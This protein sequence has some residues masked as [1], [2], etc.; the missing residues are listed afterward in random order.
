[1]RLHRRI[2]PLLAAA[3]CFGCGTDSDTVFLPLSVEF[4][5]SS[6]EAPEGSE[7]A[8]IIVRL[9]APTELSVSVDY[10]VRDVTA[11]GHDA[12]NT[13]DYSLAASG[14]LVFEP[15]STTA[16]LELRHLDDDLAEIDEQLRIELT[17]PEGA[18]LGKLDHHTHTISDDDRELL[19]D[20]QADFGATGD[21][22]TDDT[23]ALQ[24]AIDRAGLSSAAVLLLPPG[25]YQVTSLELP[26][27]LSL[28]GYGA[29]LRQ[30]PRQ[31]EN[32]KLLRLTHAG[33]DDSA[34]TLVQ[35]L[36]FDGN[37]DAQGEFT[38]WQY[39]ESDLFSLSANPARSGR[40]QLVAEDLSFE[41]TGGNGLLLG[42]NTKSS[43]CQ[44]VG[45]EVFTDLLK[46]SGGYS[47]L[48][49]REIVAAGSV[50]TTSIAITGQ[51]QGYDASHT[52]DVTL[53]DIALENGD[54]EIDVR[55]GSSVNARGITVNE[56]PF[57]LRAVRSSVRISDSSLVMGPPL[58]RFNRI[59]APYD[60][61]FENSE[62]TLHETIERTVSEPESDRTL[63]LVGV[64]WDD[65]D[66]AFEEG[67]QDVLVERLGRQTLRFDDCNFRVGS[68]VE[69][70]DTSY[71]AGSVAETAD[72]ADE[73]ANRILINGGSVDPAFDGVFAPG[74]CNCEQTP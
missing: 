34:L 59:V 60:V 2:T 72:A 17:N 22:E 57:Y 32:A 25:V 58:Y 37:R 16:T 38:D 44:L 18:R 29:T 52:V 46:L 43:V 47:T 49:A 10:T 3:F 21:G 23:A 13:R 68:D 41:N 9:N 11:S 64:T 36:T 12:C 55:D 19:V 26:A 63:V 42:P 30:A 4:D 5:S 27:G 1:M 65:V 6:S 35:G 20:V 71:V 66:H 73:D 24:A 31:S 15:G 8:G 69:P 62:L 39:Q 70:G 74:A 14:S 7:D 33:D 48:A 45:N 67:E 50:G 28:F 40:A 56:A 51:A 53:D 61:S 54:L